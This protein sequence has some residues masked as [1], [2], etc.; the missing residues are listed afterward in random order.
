MSPHYAFEAKKSLGQNFLQD[1][2]VARKIV[3]QLELCPSDRVVEIGPGPGMLTRLILEA[4]PRRFVALEKDRN[5]AGE[6]M[7]EC[8][9]VDVVNTDALAFAWERVGA[10]PDGPAW[11]IAGNLPYNVASPLMWEIVSRVGGLTRAVFMVQ[12]EVGQRLCAAPGSKTYGALSVWV[13]SFA[14]VR[15]AFVVGPSVFRPRPKVDSAVMVFSPLPE[16]GAPFDARALSLLLKRCFQNR[17]KQLQT[18]LKSCWSEEVEALLEGFG[19]NGMSR[20]EALSPTCFQGLANNV[21][22]G[23]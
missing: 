7:R 10:G 18:I 15:M 8:A 19:A 4:G 20:P 23:I 12:K 6:L 22:I 9:G 1:T 2:N 16:A 3:A 13:Q 5:W 21:K 11:K 14:R 17:R